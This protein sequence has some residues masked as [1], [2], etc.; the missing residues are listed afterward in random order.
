MTRRD[1]VILEKILDNQKILSETMKE[2]KISNAKE[3]GSINYVMR[4]GMIQIVGDV[5]ELLVPLNPEITKK[6]PLNV[7]LIKRFRDTASHNYG[8][9]SDEMAYAC[10]THCTD[11]QF[12]QTVRAL[13]E[14]IQGE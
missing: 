11:K 13:L 6:L 3:L 4:R 10:I 9:I 7:L 12:I 1:K 5:Y 8:I 2:L 14:N